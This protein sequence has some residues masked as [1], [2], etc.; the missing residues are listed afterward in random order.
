[1]SLIEIFTKS[2]GTMFR[3]RAVTYLAIVS[4]LTLFGSRIVLTGQDL[5]KQAKVL[6]P[7]IK[8]EFK[9]AAIGQSL[10][11]ATSILEKSGYY[12]GYNS[13]HA[14]YWGEPK[15]YAVQYPEAR[16][17]YIS[18]LNNVPDFAWKESENLC[19]NKT[20]IH[21]SLDAAGAILC[22]SDVA[23]RTFDLKQ[24]KIVRII[25][26]VDVPQG[27]SLESFL[28][29]ARKKYPEL[30]ESPGY[31]DGVSYQVNNPQAPVVLIALNDA[32]FA[33]R[34]MDEVRRQ[35]ELKSESAF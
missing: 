9:G 35:A 29:L 3:S 26:I 17:G 10:A 18:Y 25:G 8:M 20:Q 11:D 19:P 31:H 7:T 23:G 5:S 1:M 33:H 28:A 4:M 27:T 15:T 12:V 2:G 34:V 14:G 6:R 32:V 22:G 13:R 24:S 21:L 30:P 16:T